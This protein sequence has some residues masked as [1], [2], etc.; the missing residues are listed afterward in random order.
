MVRLF[1][2]DITQYFVNSDFTPHLKVDEPRLSSQWTPRHTSFRR[3]VSCLPKEEENIASIS[4]SERPFV[5][6]TTAAAQIYAPAHADANR[7]KVPLHVMIEH[8]I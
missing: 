2:H 3:S 8:A 7:A 5:S 4:S 6:G 1:I